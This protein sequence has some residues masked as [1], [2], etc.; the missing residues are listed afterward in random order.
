MVIRY[1][2]VCY[3][4]EG[5]EALIMRLMAT[6]RFCASA[7]AARALAEML[8]KT[9]SKPRSQLPT[10]RYFYCGSA[11]GPGGLSHAWCGTC[12]MANRCTGISIS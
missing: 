3:S 4:F 9:A 5:G 1:A 12:G 2:V 6:L 11:N 7:D 8:V 10:G